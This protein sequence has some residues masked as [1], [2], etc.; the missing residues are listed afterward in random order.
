MAGVQNITVSK[1][2][3]GIRLD[4]WFKRNFPDFPHVTM[5]KALRKGDIR[6]DKKRAKS[7]SRLEE[8]QVVRVPPFK[9]RADIG[10]PIK[11]AAKWTAKQEQELQESVIFKNYDVLVINKPAGISV[12]GGSGVKLSIDDMLG[13]LMFEKEDRP[14][15]VHRLDKD[16]SGVLVLARRPAAAANMAELFKTKKTEKIYLAVIVGVPKEKEGKISNKIMKTQIGAGKE[17]M[18]SDEE[19][20]VATTY[21]R[22]L[23][24]AG[25]Q[26][27]LV[28]LMP[29]TG[30]T[31]QLRVHMAEAGTPILG[32]G[33]YG[34]KLAF[35]NGMG[36]DMHL[37]AQKLTIP[38][39]NKH[40]SFEAE[41]PAHMV[42]TLKLLGLSARHK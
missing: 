25:T 33:K 22:V 6:V 12:Q 32:D 38:Y 40:L 29:I 5:E 28:E 30:R 7:N 16:T 14:K 19:G 13:C 31:H 36:K 11:K 17:K 23:D 20:K 3:D 2:D 26:Y 39:E 21:Y 37:H 41:L 42:A 34:G 15:L 27:S 24:T 4:R 9:P 35:G 8:G 18:R 10:K 1:D